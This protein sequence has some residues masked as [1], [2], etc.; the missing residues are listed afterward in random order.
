MGGFAQE[1][2]GSLILAA[3]AGGA[4]VFV[5]VAGGPYFFDGVIAGFLMLMGLVFGIATGADV[6]AKE[7]PANQEAAVVTTVSTL[8][9]AA[10]GAFM[11]FSY[12][13]NVFQFVKSTDTLNVATTFGIV[14]FPLSQTIGTG[15]FVTSGYL[16]GLIF[17][18]III[19][20]S[21]E[22]FFRGLWGNLSVKGL[23]PE[24]GALGAGA[25]F[26]VFHIPVY[27]SNPYFLATVFMDGATIMAVDIASGRLVTGVLAHMANN[28]LSFLL[29]GSILSVLG[30]PA[31]HIPA[32]FVAPVPGLIVPLVAFTML[33]R[34]RRR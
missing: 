33:A 31:L 20:N 34:K 14:S 7:V 4:S 24:L 6:K 5:M 17:T 12:L 25:A 3:A 15:A 30:A 10:L 11:V 1:D 28:L 2:D 13:L 8:T 32:Q 22:Q 16:L 19:P 23:G 18:G 21:E 26:M 9:F 27:G 29:Q